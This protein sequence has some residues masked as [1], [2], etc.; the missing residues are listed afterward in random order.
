MTITIYIYV[1]I[2]VAICIIRSARLPFGK[3]L[4]TAADPFVMFA[5][6]LGSLLTE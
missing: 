6:S 1:Y 3:Y 4:T 2:F 5:Y